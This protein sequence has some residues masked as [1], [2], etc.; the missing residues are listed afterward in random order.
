MYRQ[1][2]GAGSYLDVGG[3]VH[4]TSDTRVGKQRKRA[5]HIGHSFVEH[6]HV[7]TVAFNLNHAHDDNLLRCF[8]GP[9]I[10]R[11]DC[12]RCCIGKVG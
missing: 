12:A 3:V 11:R 6:R 9:K 7:R 10:M 5:R 1:R 4:D 2:S 8:M